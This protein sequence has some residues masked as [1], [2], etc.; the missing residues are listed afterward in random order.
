MTDR[1]AAGYDD[2]LHANQAQKD[3][4]ESNEHLGICQRCG[5]TGNELHS[6]FRKCSQCDGVGTLELE[7]NNDE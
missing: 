5:G 7:D 3:V 1:I 2:V 6:M 4:D